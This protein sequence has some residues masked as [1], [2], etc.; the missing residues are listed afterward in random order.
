MGQLDG[1]SSDHCNIEKPWQQAS[2]S[3][4][5]A[6]MGADLFW[7]WGDKLSN[8]QTANDGNTI[9]YGSS[10]A[11]CLITDHVKAIKAI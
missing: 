1:T 4:A 3:L 9:Y 6:G 5:S 11:S 10:D 7:Q 8:G 2:V